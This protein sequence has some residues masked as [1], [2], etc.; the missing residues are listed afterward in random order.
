MDRLVNFKVQ[1]FQYIIFESYIIDGPI[2]FRHR[3]ISDEGLSE[4]DFQRTFRW[5]KKIDWFGETNRSIKLSIAVHFSG[6]ISSLGEWYPR[7][8]VPPDR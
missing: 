5:Y 1:R 3:F 2:E 7:I 8:R 4:K 6:I